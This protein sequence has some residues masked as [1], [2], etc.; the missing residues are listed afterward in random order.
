VLVDQRLDLGPGVGD[1][2]GVVLV[3]LL[4]HAQQITE[5]AGRP[6]IG[7]P[8]G[9]GED[10]VEALQKLLQVD[11]EVGATLDLLHRRHCRM[12]HRHVGRRRSESSG[13]KRLNLGHP[14][15]AEVLQQ[16]LV[17]LLQD[18][19]LGEAVLQPGT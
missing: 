1:V 15:A 11:L 12:Y 16:P 6:A 17:A 19:Q 10:Q 7:V 3:T 5:A 9:M 2:E 14:G 18:R 13:D 4:D 8:S